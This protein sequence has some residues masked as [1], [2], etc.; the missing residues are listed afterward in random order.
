[1]FKDRRVKAIIGL[2][3]STGILSTIL[4]LCD[5]PDLIAVSYMFAGWIALFFYSKSCDLEDKLK[6]Q[7]K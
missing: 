2:L 3:V 5:L 6:E 4:R 7:E 1:M